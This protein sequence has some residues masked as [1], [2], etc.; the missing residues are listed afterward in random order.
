V[1]G[2]EGRVERT[3]KG[4]ERLVDLVTKVVMDHA[5]MGNS[6]GIF[7]RPGAWQCDQQAAGRLTRRSCP[8]PGD[9]QHAL[10]GGGS[11]CKRHVAAGQFVDGKTRKWGR[12]EWRLVASEQIIKPGYRAGLCRS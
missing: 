1:Y 7:Q 4:V 8:A 9:G 2:C 5:V 10:R 11:R 12:C 3:H 6:N